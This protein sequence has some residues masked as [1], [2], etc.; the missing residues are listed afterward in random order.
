MSPPPTHNQPPLP[1][2]LLSTLQASHVP[3]VAL[4]EACLSCAS[5]T[6]DDIQGYPS[7]FGADLDSVMLGSVKDYSRQI[8]V[9][10]GK[11]DWAKE[12]TD[13]T[14]RLAGMVKLA[15]EGGAGAK[16]G[17]GLLGKLSEKV[18]GG[19]KDKKGEAEGEVPG[20]FPSSAMEPTPSSEV[21]GVEARLSILNAS[22]W[23]S[24]GEEGLETVVVLP[25][26]KVVMQVPQTREGA[27]DLVVSWLVWMRGNTGS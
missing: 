5:S 24:T 10:T 4:S 15:Y 7:G 21:P 16:E 11:S 20:L 27:H 25:D 26:F 2:A 13:D 22:F 14:A 3:L 8:L 1:P 12:V 23:S 6:S 18:G 19:K 17:K 9:S